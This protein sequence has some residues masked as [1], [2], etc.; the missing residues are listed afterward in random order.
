M[1]Q[2][3]SNFWA[4]GKRRRL[5][6]TEKRILGVIAVIMSLY[7]IIQSTFFSIQPVMHYCIHLTF[8]MVLCYLLYTPQRESKR[9]HIGKVDYVVAAVV[10]V[11]GIYYATQ[12]SRYLLRWPQVDP[13]SVPDIIVGIIFAVLVIDGTRR[14]MGMVLPTIA[15]VFTLYTFFGHLFP[16]LLNHRELIPIDILD[17]LV[18]TTNGIFTSPIAVSSTYVFL[19][20]LFG[21]FFNYSGAGDFFY[22]FSMAVAGR[23][24]GGAGKVSIVSSALFGMINGSPTAN[25]ATTGS[26]TIPM[27]KKVGYDTDFSG[28]VC[29]VAS[30]GGGVMP[31]IMGTAAFLMVEMAGIPYKDIAIAALV[32]GVLYYLALMLMVHF[33]AKKL[34]LKGM[35]K[36][37]LPDMKETLKKGFQFIL[38][39]VVL[40]VMIMQGYTPSMAAV[41]GIV[42]VILASFLRKETRMTPKKIWMALEDGAL[43][44]VI[45]SMSC[46]IAGMVICGLMTTGLS[47]K[48]A[49]LVLSLGGK[50]VLIALAIT[51][52]LC[53]LLGMGMPVAAAYALTASLAIPSLY[54]LGVAPMSAHMFVVYFSTMSA[55]TP[56]VAV[57]SYAAAGI[58]EGNATKIGWSAC[59]LGSVS[60]IVPFMFV[61][62]PKLLVTADNFSL[63]TIW[64]IFTA[65]AGVYAIS[66]GIEGWL[67][68]KVNP[69][70]RVLLLIS[71][72]L[73]MYPETITDYIGL[74]IFAVLALIS[75]LEN[76]KEKDHV[77][78]ASA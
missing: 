48:L 56:P 4:G 26:F 51:A 47:G 17:Q 35:S 34:G 9:D 25:V 31:P 74:A 64:I 1:K 2:T 38:P 55:I 77:N 63:G 54:E 3:F 68:R 18:F 33:R 27:M 71:G 36:E 12:V 13:L 76:K 62:Q 60:F 16:G 15:I 42:C 37:E 22:N 39:L 61:L 58:A 75:I 65:L 23:Y 70:V 59:L 53:I 29:A 73:M 40:V 43:Q 50:N 14:T 69:L 21:S 49:S 10:A 11:A 45:I 7:Q 19:F 72:L 57:A 32:P 28:A 8:I 66:A 41:A 30:T 46:A 44:A 6:G 78:P 52:V 20:C 24:T 67:F 5:E